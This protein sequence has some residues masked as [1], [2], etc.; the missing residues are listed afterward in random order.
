M[1]DF[2]IANQITD[3]MGLFTDIF[4]LLATLIFA[5]VT[6]AFYFLHRAPL[7]TKVASFVFLISAIAFVTI[8]ALGAFLHFEA[9]WDM[10]AARAA[11][12]SA[13]SLIVASNNERAGI[14][15]KAG[16]WSVALV[17]TGTIIMCF[18]MTFVWQRE[19][20]PLALVENGSP[21]EEPQNAVK[22]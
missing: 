8:N 10:V 20:D 13:S 1:S 17:V 5:Y 9:L 18:W 6:G 15:L 19:E 7:F 2:E 3:M 12:P 22:V 14:L 4:G 16:F 11:E 21:A